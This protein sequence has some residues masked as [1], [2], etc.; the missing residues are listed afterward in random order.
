MGIEVQITNRTSQAVQKLRDTAGNRMH[1]MVNVVR[2]N[3]LE[4]LSGN[5]TGRTYRV[6]G[7]IRTYTASAPGEPPAQRLGELRQSVSTEVKVSKDEV[8]G[9]VGTGKDYGLMLELGTKN[10][11]ARPW[12][13]PSF[14]RSEDELERIKNR[15]W[16]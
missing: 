4:T 7:S 1:E 16:L 10:M 6:P 12:L 13:L 14:Q 5:R 15:P 11:A 3:T 2:N 9:R 8:K